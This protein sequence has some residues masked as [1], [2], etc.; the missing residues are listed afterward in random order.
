MD[1][2]ECQLNK[3]LML[4]VID[5]NYMDFSLSFHSVV[6]QI[7]FQMELFR[8][9]LCFWFTLFLCFHLLGYNFT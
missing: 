4:Q 9:P 3:P 5:V 8:L 1:I 2:I 6:D 7:R